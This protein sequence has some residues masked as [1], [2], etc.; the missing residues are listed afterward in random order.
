[1]LD[2]HRF[3][4]ALGATPHTTVTRRDVIGAWSTALANGQRVS[5]VETLVDRLVPSAAGEIG[6]A[7]RVHGLAG[8]VVRPHLLVALGPRP[9][10]PEAHRRWDEVAGEID[11]YRQRWGVDSRTEVLGVT[12]DAP[13]LRRLPAGRLAEHL[14]VSRRIDETMRRLGRADRRELDRGERS[15]GR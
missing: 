4:S 5:A 9:A 3:A 6:V 7:E 11:R 12:P 1:V 13:A 8:I 15:M 10:T 2:E 14:A